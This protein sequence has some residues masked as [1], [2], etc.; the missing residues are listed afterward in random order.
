MCTCSL[1]CLYAVHTRV[2]SCACMCVLT[3]VCIYIVHTCACSLMCGGALVLW[4]ELPFLRRLLVRWEQPEA[5]PLL[6]RPTQ[7]AHTD[8]A[9]LTRLR[10]PWAGRGGGGPLEAR[11]CVGRGR[12]SGPEATLV[13]GAW[14][15][16]HSEVRVS[17]DADGPAETPEPSAGK[18]G[19][20]EP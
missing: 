10:A 1:V 17:M 11:A 16:G 19:P 8:R 4:S 20:H 6:A 15:D 5:T 14:A 18:G 3:C 2:C 7:Q 13:G 9:P 12:P